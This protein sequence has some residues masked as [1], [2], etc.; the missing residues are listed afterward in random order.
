MKPRLVACPACGRL[1]EWSVENRWRPFCSERCKTR[2]LAAWAT[3][4]YRVGTAEPDA[5][6][7]SESE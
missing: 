5:G 3:E 2:D 1:S 7:T 6:L 4:Q